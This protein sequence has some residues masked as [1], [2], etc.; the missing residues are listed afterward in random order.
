MSQIMKAFLGIFLIM[1]MAV[2]SSGVL[3]GFLTVV[4]AQNL[5]SQIITELEDSDFYRDVARECF[6]SA[7][8]Q[9]DVLGITF[10][11]ADNTTKTATQ[12]AQIPDSDQI[13]R[14]RVELKFNYKV[15]FFGIEQE[16]ILSG[17]A[18]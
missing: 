4:Q 3:S 8:R 18:M 7:E 16:H 11:M 2:T 15:A 9:G 17:Y 1:F 5:H 12:A 6:E 13:V 10:Y 14:A